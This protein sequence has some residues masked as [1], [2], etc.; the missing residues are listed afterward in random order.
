MVKS[1]YLAV[2]QT[3]TRAKHRGIARLIT[4]FPAFGERFIKNYM[5]WESQDI[6]WTPVTTPLER[7][8]LAVVTTAGVHHPSQR[9]FDWGFCFSG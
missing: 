6:P 5:P 4:R 3:L 7:A 2:K 8:H 9:P 1:A